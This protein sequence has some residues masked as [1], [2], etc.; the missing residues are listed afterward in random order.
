M[1]GIFISGDNLASFHCNT[2]F[3]KHLNCHFIFMQLILNSMQKYQPYLKLTCVSTGVTQ[4]YCFIETTFI[5]VT[6]Y[7]N[8]EVSLVYTPCAIAMQWLILLINNYRSPSWRST[9]TPMLEHSVS[10]FQLTLVV[11]SRRM[12]TA[13]NLPAILV[14]LVQRAEQLVPLNTHLH[15]LLREL[16]LLLLLSVQL[17]TSMQATLVVNRVSYY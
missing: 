2:H 4:S 17:E 5:A 11:M 16:S 8:K 12:A 7:Q 10:P 13:R 3:C 9:T 15:L 14:L 6:A 1:R